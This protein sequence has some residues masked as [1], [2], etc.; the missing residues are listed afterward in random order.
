MNQF[1]YLTELDQF[2]D[3]WPF[4]LEGLPLLNSSTGGRGGIPEE[5]F[6]K[7]LLQI[8]LGNMKNGAVLVVC[9]KNGKPLAYTV[10]INNTA[11]FDERSA[12]CY[13]LYSNNKCAGVV[14]QLHVEVLKW[15]RLNEYVKLYAASKR[16]TGSAV[17]LFEKKWGFQKDSLVFSKIV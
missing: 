10:L 5:R 13:A 14:K 17:R 9:S 8:A 11:P 16:I 2:L 3:W 12:L 6:F 4:F 7:I 1:I 15:C